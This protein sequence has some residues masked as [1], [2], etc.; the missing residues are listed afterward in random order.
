MK[1][2]RSKPEIAIDGINIALYP[3]ILCRTLY[4]CRLVQH[5]LEVLRS[6]EVKYRW[7]YPFSLNGK[8]ATLRTKDDL[9]S[10]VEILDL[11]L[12]DFID[13]RINHLGSLLQRPERWQE[14]PAKGQRGNHSRRHR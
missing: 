1:M 11:P 5:L 3:D 8:T 14:I 7:R 6:A 12:V 13:W 4:Q 10:F 9:E 2:A